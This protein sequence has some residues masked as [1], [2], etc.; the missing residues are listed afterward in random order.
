MTTLQSKRKFFESHN[1]LPK[2]INH[3]CERDVVV[4]NWKTWS[5]KSECGS[6]MVD[7][8]RNGIT[9]GITIHKKGYC[10]NGDG[11]LGFRCPIPSKEC[12]VGFESGLDLDHINGDHM[13]NVPSNVKTYCKLCH[14][15]KSIANGDTINTKI[16]ARKIG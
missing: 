10:E 5:F 1:S 16:S 12:F 15:R 11:H 14:G 4:R 13:D 6:C 7:R 3:G 2:C 9:K 8:K